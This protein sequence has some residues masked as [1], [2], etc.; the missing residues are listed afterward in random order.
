MKKK[1]LKHAN[2]IRAMSLGLTA[3]IS[4]TPMV[5]FAAEDGTGVPTVP[6]PIDDDHISQEK[7]VT[8][9][10]V[11][12][13]ARQKVVSAIDLGDTAK[14][15][16]EQLDISIDQAT[17]DLQAG[18]SDYEEY[19]LTDLG[20][21]KD[22]LIVT[23][24]ASGLF[25]EKITASGDAVSD[26]L[27]ALLEADQASAEASSHNLAAQK[28][29]DQAGESRTSAEA[30][31]F[32]AV[33]VEAAKNADAA[34]TLAENKV[35]K[36]DQ[37]LQVADQA[38]QNAKQQAERAEQKANAAQE[39][40]E[41]ATANAE[42]ARQK[43]EALETALTQAKEALESAKTSSQSEYETALGTYNSTKEAWEQAVD[44]KLDALQ[45]EKAAKE[46]LQISLDEAADA[47]K[48]VAE[49]YEGAYNTAQ[50]TTNLSLQELTAAKTAREQLNRDTLEAENTLRN[51]S[52]SAAEKESA[53]R[54]ILASALGSDR[55]FTYDAATGRFTTGEGE[56]TRIFTITVKE[57]GA[58]QVDEI[59][60]GAAEPVK[61]AEQTFTDGSSA[62][63]FAE[64]YAQQGYAV[65]YSPIGCGQMTIRAYEKETRILSYTDNYWG[66][67]N[68]LGTDFVGTYG[69]FAYRDNHGS[70]H[71]VFTEVQ[72]YGHDRGHEYNLAYYY[73][74]ANG[75]KVVLNNGQAKK[76]YGAY[77]VES[78]ARR[79]GEKAVS[80]KTLE[81]RTQAIAD[82]DDLITKKQGI[83]DQ[84]VINEGLSKTQA[85]SSQSEF[86]E[87][88]RQS[89]AMKSTI[90][91]LAQDILDWQ[92]MKDPSTGTLSCD[93]AEYQAYINAIR[94]LSG[95]ESARDAAKNAYD[96]TYA[97]YAAKALNASSLLQ[98]VETAKA[99]VEAAGHLVAE[100]QDLLDLDSRA[101]GVNRAE[102]LIAQSNLESAREK[103]Q[104]SLEKALQA[105]EEAQDAFAAVQLASAR[106]KALQMQEGNTGSNTPVEN[107]PSTTY[108]AAAMETRPVLTVELDL[109]E[110][111]EVLG[112]TREEVAAKIDGEKV[113][114]ETETT[115]DLPS[116][117]KT[118]DVAEIV[119]EDIP[120]VNIDDEETPKADRILDVLTDETTQTTFS[121]LI[122]LATAISGAV[123]G[124]FFLL[125][126]KKNGAGAEEPGISAE[127]FKEPK[128]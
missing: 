90:N 13:N 31:G 122:G 25:E 5:T 20:E 105:R 106:V 102:L 72:H 36:A 11:A 28:A 46:K 77:R 82:A 15:S 30:A 65:T 94:D 86:E 43:A 75:N 39:E 83:Y 76:V 111:P 55:T 51:A 101:F 17:A 114:L 49:T 57:Q 123:I 63:S 74:D 116:E 58:V 48:T 27:T 118:E 40:L 26:A 73:L 121:F 99:E 87:A 38:Y 112:V 115:E 67:V 89:G 103:Y 109:P 32:E 125:F 29:A 117:T 80:V 91:G 12:Q 59:T 71:E 45:K 42:M 50:Q 44:D 108:R 97:E 8:N 96:E 14:E 127:D 52:A 6:D 126:G 2:I 18:V 85:E 78:I 84:A 64:Q 61:V 47:A 95:K 3:V 19:V 124:F 104:L 21:A 70:V 35:Q 16:A 62:I 119:P 128:E 81:N 53:A 120:P 113:A 110:D 79:E 54:E 4:M 24:E 37:D 100:L 34:A 60:T 41:E 10:E 93:L 98:Q 66:Y 107:T 56:Q 7:T 9:E 22:A 23:E 1:G 33:A 68:S 69:T 92:S 88:E